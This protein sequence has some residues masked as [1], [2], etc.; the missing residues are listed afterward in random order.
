[1]R[2]LLQYPVTQAE[3]ISILRKIIEDKRENL[4]D[5]PFGDIT[6][7]VLEEILKDLYRVTAHDEGIQDE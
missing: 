1:M 7:A 6:V 4:A 5:L 3:K 2:N